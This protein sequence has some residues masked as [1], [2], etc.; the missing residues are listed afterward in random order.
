[1]KASPPGNVWSNWTRRPTSD[2]A[3]PGPWPSI[4]G[5]SS[6]ARSPPARYSHTRPAWERSFPA[7]WH[8]VAAVKSAGQLKLF[9]DGKLVSS[10]SASA[11]DYN[12]DSDRPL[13]I[14]FGANDYFRGRLRD[15]R[16][17]RRAL[18]EAEIRGLVNES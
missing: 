9:V 12:L 13:H 8:H 11:A 15:V 3:A 5:K 14:G 17:Y 16:L 4:R 7:G 1:M 10:S 2:T 18:S 6:A